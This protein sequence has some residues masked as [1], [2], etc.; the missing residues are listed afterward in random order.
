MNMKHSLLL[1]L[2]LVVASCC[3]GGVESIRQHPQIKEVMKKLDFSESYRMILCVGFGYPDES[4]E[5]KNRD[6]SKYR[7]VE[8]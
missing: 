2:A 1:A 3:G 8:F 7:F 4:P 5:A 6:S